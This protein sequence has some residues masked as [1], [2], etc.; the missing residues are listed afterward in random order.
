MGAV[1]SLERSF[2]CA[3]RTMH[4]ASIDYC[5]GVPRVGL[6]KPFIV[7]MDCVQID[8]SMRGN[9]GSE[10]SIGLQ[11]WHFQIAAK[12][13]IEN[14]LALPKNGSISAIKTPPGNGQRKER[15]R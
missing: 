15:R 12:E 1:Q 9:S 14:M 13:V 8:P 5:A 7:V 2:R 11:G 6:K 3:H 4:S 10:K